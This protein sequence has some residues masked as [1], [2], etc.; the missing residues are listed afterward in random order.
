MTDTTVDSVM[1]LQ[2]DGGYDFDKILVSVKGQPLG[3]VQGFLLRAKDYIYPDEKAAEAKEIKPLTHK[4]KL[5]GYVQTSGQLG[6]ALGLVASGLLEGNIPRAALGSFN[7]LR[8]STK[9]ISDFNAKS[10]ASSHRNDLVEGGVAA[11]ANSIGFLN[12]RSPEELLAVSMGV[13]AWATKSITSFLHMKRE[14]SSDDKQ[15]EINENNVFFKNRRATTPESA[16]QSRV[17]GLIHRGLEKIKDVSIESTCFIMS[18]APP[19]M[20]TTRAVSYLMDGINNGDMA[21]A[22]G[23]A[24]FII[25]AGLM[26]FKDHGSYM[27]ARAERQQKREAKGDLKSKMTTDFTSAEQGEALCAT[28][29]FKECGGQSIEWKVSV[30]DQSYGALVEHSNKSYNNFTPEQS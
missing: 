28:L 10:R 25:G 22:G 7:A 1:Q 11:S 19:V 20:M 29:R 6:G 23:G 4:D 14:K 8:S 16:P 21:M 13:T 5:S 27:S 24:S 30:A 15:Q 2:N 18:H 17:V 26:L 3:T 9:I 12:V